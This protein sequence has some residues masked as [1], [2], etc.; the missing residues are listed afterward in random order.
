MDKEQIKLE[1]PFRE[2]ISRLFIFRG[3]YIFVLMFVIIP[4]IIWV[5]FLNMLH[6]W[7]MLILGK[8]QSFLWGQNVKFF[9]WMTKW[10][11][12]LGSNVDLKPGFWW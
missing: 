7:Y 11:A 3:F 5:G 12:Y 2:T 6:F 4:L 1:V 10:Q 9:V 8:R